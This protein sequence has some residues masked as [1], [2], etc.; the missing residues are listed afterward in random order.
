MP[1]ALERQPL[2][3]L[4]VWV[5]LPRRVVRT[6]LVTGSKGT[7]A[8][9][10]ALAKPGHACFDRVEI[11]S[12][13]QIIALLIEERDKLDL[14]IEALSGSEERSGQPP[15]DALA[16]ATVPAVSAPATAAPAVRKRRRFTAAQKKTQAEKMKLY[17]A[18][19][20][21]EQTKK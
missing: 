12:T 7:E 8:A 10:K 19:K 21:K 2:N 11:M 17:W 20:R 6:R 15:T 1:I 13:D 14:A 9:P 16:L 3:C 5:D 4:P 18:A